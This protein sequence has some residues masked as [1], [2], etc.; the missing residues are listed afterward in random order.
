MLRLA[1]SAPEVPGASGS[2]GIPCFRLTERECG[3]LGTC[4][5][6]EAFSQPG[7]EGGVELRMGSAGA[8]TH[9]T[10][11]ERAAWTRQGQGATRGLGHWVR[12]R[13]GVW[14]GGGGLCKERLTAMALRRGAEPNSV[15]PQRAALRSYLSRTAS[16]DLSDFALSHRRGWSLGRATHTFDLVA[17]PARAVPEGS[18]SKRC[19]NRMGETSS[20]KGSLGA[21]TQ[22]G[23]GGVRGGDAT[24]GGLPGASE[25]DER[26]Q[27]Q[28]GNRRLSVIF[29][30]WRCGTL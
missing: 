20:R 24:Q 8:L 21:S 26:W 1:R 29:S 13:S 11:R 19:N 16:P 15:E 18:A 17:M 14:G 7:L 22:A 3:C 10:G 6:C 5:L 30:D 28:Q 23:S 2:T 4:E 12:S 25:P 27:H 9:R